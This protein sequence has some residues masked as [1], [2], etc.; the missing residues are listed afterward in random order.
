MPEN[1]RLKSFEGSKGSCMLPK[2]KMVCDPEGSFFISLGFRKWAGRLLSVKK[3]T[4]LGGNMELFKVVPRIQ[5][6]Y[7]LKPEETRRDLLN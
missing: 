7:V 4:N 3:V 2:L 1:L 6:A 5:W